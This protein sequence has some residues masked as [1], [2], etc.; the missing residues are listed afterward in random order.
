MPIEVSQ[1]ENLAHVAFDT[2]VIDD[3][4]IPLNHR[5]ATYRAQNRL[6]IDSNLKLLLNFD[7]P[8]LVKNLKFDDYLNDFSYRFTTDM[9][10]DTEDYFD[11]LSGLEYDKYFYKAG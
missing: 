7:D 11:F 10:E 3:K 6:K 5:T 1:V 4:W 2:R 8:E 9:I